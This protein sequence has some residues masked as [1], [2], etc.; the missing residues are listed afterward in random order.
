MA[1]AVLHQLKVVNV[2][3]TDK[4]PHVARRQWKEANSKCRKE[5]PKKPGR[6]EEVSK[7]RDKKKMV[8]AEDLY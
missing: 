1:S 6:W 3:V 7:G 5:S 8:S 2:L 4:Q